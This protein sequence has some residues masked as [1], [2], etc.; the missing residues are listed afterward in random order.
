MK[1]KIAL[2]LMCLLTLASVLS[3]C[4][5]INTNL[6][7]YYQTTVVSIEYPNGDKINISKK[8]LITSFNNYGSTL[9]EQGSSMEEALQ[10]SMT[11]LINQKVLIKDSE[12][13]IKLSNLD[14]NTVWTETKDAIIENL[15]SFAEKVREK[16]EINIPSDDDETE[17][18]SV[19]Y[20][21]YERKAEVLKEDGVY[22]IKLVE[23]NQEDENVPLIFD[24]ENIDDI[25]NNIYDVINEKTKAD[26]NA[27]E[28]EKLEAKVFAESLKKYIRTL[29]VNEE[30]QKLSTD[31]ESIFK[32]E[33]KRIYENR[34]DSIKIEKM[35]EYI[36]GSSNMSPITV[37]DVLDKYRSMIINSYQTYK[38]LP[39]QFDE[40]VLDKFDSVNYIPNDDYFFVSHI[41]LKFNKEQQAE[42]DELQTLLEKQL[43]SPRVYQER[44]KELKNQITASSRN[45]NGVFEG[46]TK[47][48]NDI[49]NEVKNAVKSGSNEEKSEHFR[50]LLYK[51]NQ[52]D[53]ALNGEYLYVVGKENSRMV[54]SFNEAGRELHAKGEF[55]AVSDLVLSQYGA[56]ILFYA[57]PVKN[58]FQIYSIDAFNFSDEDIMTMSQT[59]LNPLNNK[60]LFDKVYES[61]SSVKNSS[62]EAMYINVLK[63]D[64]KITK[65]KNAYKDLLD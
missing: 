53:G 50:N 52:D 21:P 6:A 63:N 64:L 46:D 7:K 45:E 62:N 28:S 26:E 29:T 32:R 41:L 19:V 44:V 38:A 35:Q 59:L 5:L 27:T 11:A 14:K 47:N 30:G 57:G 25:C 34:L 24:S 12:S 49:L 60:T 58:V 9:I 23:K 20:T 2:L 55:G 51:Y 33:I 8:E 17:T 37:K 42:Y 16:W 22:V 31:S 36:A 56:H 4:T 3:G 18:A 61:L 10:Q 40:D 15:N 54:D 13:K 39:S 65:Y 43:I 1:K 48:A